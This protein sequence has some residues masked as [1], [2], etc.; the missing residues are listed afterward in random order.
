MNCSGVQGGEIVQDNIPEQRINV[1]LFR[2]LCTGLHDLGSTDGNGETA[3]FLKGQS[4]AFAVTEGGDHGIP[5]AYRAAQRNRNSGTVEYVVSDKE[6]AFCTEGNN[7]RP[8]AA[9]ME[10]QRCQ[11]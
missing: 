7:D 3:G 1:L 5:G 2:R 9:P 4:D 10:S 8:D 11:P 6:S